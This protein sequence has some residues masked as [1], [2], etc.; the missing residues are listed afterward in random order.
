M[1][2]N[3]FGLVQMVGKVT[4]IDKPSNSCHFT[5]SKKKH[6]D[7]K[8]L[9]C[10]TR[11]HAGCYVTIAYNITRNHEQ[12]SPLNTQHSTGKKQ[13]LLKVICPT[14]GGKNVVH[15]HYVKIFQAACKNVIANL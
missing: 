2:V 1:N 10:D 9:L 15:C 6:K 14:R 13:S 12:V 5:P 7:R 4:N 11:K 3:G 8:C